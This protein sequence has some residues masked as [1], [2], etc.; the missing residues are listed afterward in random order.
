MKILV[1][2][3]RS[4]QSREAL[5]YARETFPDAE[6]TALHVIAADSYWMAFVD[7]SAAV[8]SYEAARKRAEELLATA[9][10]ETP[11]IETR[12]EVGSPAHEIV[13]YAGKGGLIRS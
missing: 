3:D 6:I 13:D 4:A 12:I 1:P 11:G 9:R 10:S 7:D 8:P 2:I 5:G